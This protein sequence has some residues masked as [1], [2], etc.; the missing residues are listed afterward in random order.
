ML[1]N[2]VS[3]TR[4]HLKD[5]GNKLIFRGKNIAY[6]G[7]LALSC[8]AAGLSL[9]GCGGEMSK[10]K[11]EPYV[12]IGTVRAS[13]NN[14]NSKA[15]G[16]KWAIGIGLNAIFGEKE[17]FE[18]E[19]FKQT[20]GV[21]IVTTAE[22][23]DDKPRMFS[24]KNEVYWKG[25]CDVFSRAD[26]RV[27][28]FGGAGLN[29]LRR[30]SPVFPYTESRF[31]ELYFVN[32]TIGLGVKHEKGYYFEVGGQESVWSDTDS[33]QKP[34]G[35]LSPILSAGIKHENIFLKGF[36]SQDSFG[37]DGSQPDYKLSYYGLQIGWRF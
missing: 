12:E 7:V 18:K 33:G 21:K 20:Y 19:S 1:E 37:A 32:A 35:K 25:S 3:K 28:L 4:N 36:C 17:G 22:S 27:Y 23:T 29:Q 11:F 16:N 6:N 8:V 31:G 15:S 34:K 30:N 10:P 5:V 26:T 2:L 14:D 9:F 24:N 13:E